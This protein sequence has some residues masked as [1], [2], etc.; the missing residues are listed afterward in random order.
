MPES[1]AG[2][3]AVKIMVAEDDSFTRRLLESMFSSM[4]LDVIFAVNGVDGL[5]KFKEHQ[6]D[7]VLADFNMPEMNGL[8]MFTQIKELSPKVKFVLMTIYRESDV[9][10]EAINMG[11][12]RFIE[13]PI[14]K[15]K[16]EN[17]VNSLTGEISLSKQLARHQSLLRAYRQGVD[18]STIFSVLDKNGCFTYVNKNLCH[19][20]GYKD[21]DLIG[22][23]YS[24]IRKNGDTNPISYT[25]VSDMSSD[26]IW[27]GCL[28]NLK[29]NGEEFVSEI[30]LMPL[31][32]ENI[33]TGYISIEQDMSTMV[34]NHKTHLQE[35]FNADNSIM[36]AYEKNSQ[37]SLV[38]T[39]FLNFFNYKSLEEAVENEFCF[40]SYFSES[41]E[42]AKAVRMSNCCSLDMMKDFFTDI[43]T[44]KMKKIS[45]LSAADNK[46]YD[47]APQIFELDQSY[48]GL[49]N[50]IV[51]RL[52]DITELE[53]LRKEELNS[54]ML[55]SIGKLSAGI[56]H[57]INT[58]LTY[59]KGNAELLAG[60]LEDVV[61]KGTFDEMKDYFDSINDGI[62]R[63]GLI[64][65]SMR[66]VTGE[67]K[68]EVEEI[69]L[70]STFVVAGR[71]I[72]NRA[73]HV[74]P[75]YIN[76]HKLSLDLDLNEESFTIK[77]APKMLEQLWII[78][79]NNSLDQLTQSD[80]PFE[81]KYIKINIE[82]YDC[83]K[84]LIIIADNG[85]GFA[86]SM[87]GKLFDLFA[88]TKRHKGMG[89]GLNIA[90]KII[91]KHNGTIKPYNS[92]DGAVFEILI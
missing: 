23:H 34:L 87:I 73:K 77:A 4:D 24:V 68:F 32:N 28:V 42:L 13:K 2:Y 92:E 29:K 43:L 39:S 63:I 27:Q 6:P 20:Y 35:F 45:M 17:V 30:T 18:S 71:M 46:E 33:L 74:T 38:N 55:A 12:H 15:N 7:I 36:F 54:T 67:A 59:I 47:I 84:Y 60:E 57:E 41:E 66:E 76:G 49:E 56:T 14:Y 75:I 64:I 53:N 88:S 19:V 25:N 65:D 9:L 8:E 21:Y 31:Y 40:F 37:L 26:R 70:F 22:K 62:N 52:N 5:E 79:L 91:D 80:F 10:I 72:Y 48:L 44:G 82:P 3:S 50:L 83:G 58:P 81:K 11:V 86:A 69:N 90:K 89:I 61:D 51:I 16:L 85:G 78:L 1:T